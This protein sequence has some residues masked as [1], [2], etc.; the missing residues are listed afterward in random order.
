[1]SAE[2]KVF[3]SI[4]VPTY[5]RAKIIGETIESVLNQKFTD[6]ELLIIDDGGTDNTKEIVES[7]NDSRVFYYKKENAERG[8]A[9]NFGANLARG[10]YLN[11]LDSDDLIYPNHLECAY[12]FINSHPPEILFLHHDNLFESGI[13][14]VDVPKKEIINDLLVIKG[15]ILSCDGSFIKRSVFEQNQFSENREMSASE[16][17]ELWLRL[18]ARF[19]I[20]FIPLATSCIRQHDDRSVLNVDVEGLILRKKLVLK[21][22]FSDD[23]FKLKYGKFKSHLYADAYSYIALHLVLAKHKKHGFK[24]IIKSIQTRPQILMRRRIWAT[25]KHIIF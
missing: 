3:F 9:R 4:I 24:Y 12:N 15:N 19:P 20:H 6:F 11:F 21:S 16:D 8:A 25:I 10:R 13:K 18:A 2:Y 7:I 5:N 1:M 17:Y 14:K 22:V 23:L